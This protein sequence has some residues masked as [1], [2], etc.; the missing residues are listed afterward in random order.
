MTHDDGTVDQ[1][2][3]S[4]QDTRP[5]GSFTEVFGETVWNNTSCVSHGEP[6]PC[7]DDLWPPSGLR[8]IWF[9]SRD[10]HEEGTSVPPSS[11]KRPSNA[12]N[13]GFRTIFPASRH[14]PWA[15]CEDCSRKV[16]GACEKIWETCARSETEFILISARLSHCDRTLAW[17]LLGLWVARSR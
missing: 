13:V 15:K 6:P 16:A 9:S 12:T 7:A 1:S 11:E 4:S 8:N 3:S 14:S 17:I 5:Q 2:W 10:A